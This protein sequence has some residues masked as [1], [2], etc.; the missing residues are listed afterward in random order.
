MILHNDIKNLRTEG[1]FSDFLI[2]E[3]NIQSRKKGMARCTKPKFGEKLAEI[4]EINDYPEII[5][6]LFEKSREISMI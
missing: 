2:K 1:K 4:C 3:V 6:V 5:S